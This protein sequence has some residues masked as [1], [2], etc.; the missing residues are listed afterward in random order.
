MQLAFWA[1][2][3]H[4]WLTSS[5]SSTETPKIFSTGLLS[6]SSSCWISPGLVECTFTWAHFSSSSRSVWMAFLPSVVPTALLILT[7]GVLRLHLG[8]TALVPRQTFP[9]SAWN[10][11]LVAWIPSSTSFFDLD[12]SS[13]VSLS[14]LSP[15]LL[16]LCSRFPLC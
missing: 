11:F 16:S 9:Q 1:A 4:W 6:M 14:V 5:F 8:P 3:V 2:S 12:A 13:S 15:S 10:F 7:E